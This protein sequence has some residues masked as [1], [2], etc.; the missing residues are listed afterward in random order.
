MGRL[1]VPDGTGSRDR[2]P[3]GADRFRSHDVAVGDAVGIG[4]F[5][6]S[7]RTCAAC[8]DGE[9]Q[10][11]EHGASF[12][13]NSVE[14]DGTTPT[15]GGYSSKITVDEK[16]VLRVPANLPLDGAAPLLCAGITTYAP[17]KRYGAKPG[18]EVGIV[19]LGGL[20][21]MGV[22]L[23]HAMGARVTVF[24]HSPSKREAA[25]ALGADDFISTHDAGWSTTNALRFDLIL[26]TV[27][28]EH[29]YNEYLNVV[30]RGGTMAI[31]GI[32]E[33]A[34]PVHAFALVTQRRALAGSMIGGIAET[35]EMLDFCG[36]HNVVADIELT[37]IQ[38]IEAA[39]DRTVKSDVRY[40][41][42]I[43]IATLEAS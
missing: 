22:K 15:F 3:R 25:I 14:Q 38:Q 34:L 7:D 8:T 29:D 37:P 31:V 1:D 13:Y 35:Q 2:R 36:E 40:R 18:A 17:L 6:D 42:V 26:D 23:A 32:P 11:C 19:G 10:Y 12:T 16:Y 4:C 30:K 39:Y 43:D 9:E 24:S 33:Q 41:F 21:H 28:A 5:V 20:G 27:S